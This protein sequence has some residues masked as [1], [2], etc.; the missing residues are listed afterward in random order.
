MSQDCNSRARC[1]FSRGLAMIALGLLLVG[2]KCGGPTLTVELNVDAGVTGAKFSIWEEQ[3]RSL[4]LVGTYSESQSLALDVGNY[5]VQSLGNDAFG[6]L[7]G[8][9]LKAATVTLTMAVH[10]R[11]LSSELAA[12]VNFVPGRS[13][14]VTT[15]DAA[16]VGYTLLLP[17]DAFSGPTTITL[18]PFAQPLVSF[19]NGNG[20]EVSSTLQPTAPVY[21]EVRGGSPDAALSSFDTTRHLW[22]PIPGTI[23]DDDVRFYQLDHFSSYM[24]GGPITVVN[25]PAMPPDFS[26][27]F[28]DGMDAYARFAALK[29]LSVEALG[30]I[31]AR[32]PRGGALSEQEQALVDWMAGLVKEL[33]DKLIDSA[34]ATRLEIA[35]L[36][37]ALT[38]SLLA[39]NLAASSPTYQALDD[40]FNRC[41]GEA[42]NGADCSVQQASGDFVALERQRQIIR[43]ASGTAAIMGKDGLAL[44]LAASLERCKSSTCPVQ[45]VDLTSADQPIP[46]LGTAVVVNSCSTTCG[47]SCLSADASVDCDMSQDVAEALRL[48]REMCE[49][50]S[51]CGFKWWMTPPGPGAS[52]WDCVD[53]CICYG[54]QAN[55]YFAPSTCE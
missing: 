14:W 40:M 7:R 30:W 50:E 37:L 47:Q 41:L 51:A 34:C 18:T 31:S 1:Q 16:G 39:Q 5:W 13:A 44:Q 12:H 27:T 53:H 52:R 19:P 10:G 45:A 29:G 8:V 36:Q 21:L 23:D 4:R 25:S 6:E 9:A 55:L 20:F 46:P 3:G 33:S 43:Y 42:L 11:L 24:E 49:H 38:S 35:Q 17:A 26:V 54:G 48:C 2:G 22:V 28:T 32:H 15:T